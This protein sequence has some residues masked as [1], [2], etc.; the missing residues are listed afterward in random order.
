[1]SKIYDVLIIG[2]GP[3]G[4]ACGIEA[5]K[6]GLDYVII[7]KGSIA[8][9]IRNYPIHMNFFSTADNIA[10]ADIPFAVAG[11]KANRVE[12]LQYYRKVAEYFQL[13]IQL[14]T[15]VTKVQKTE[16]LFKI[17]TERETLYQAKKVILA[18]I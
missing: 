2:A 17:Q 13:N 6:N 15:R 16:N 9:A 3:C 11:A 18:F 10:I 14:F 4:L 12:A 1:M 8:E 5:Q 7:E